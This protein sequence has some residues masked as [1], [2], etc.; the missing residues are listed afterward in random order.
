MEAINTLPTADR[1]DPSAPYIVAFDQGTTSSRTI[2]FNHSGEIVS[3]AQQELERSF[4]RPGW[5]Q[6]DAVDIWASQLSTFTQALTQA[7]IHPSFIAAAAIANQRE[8]TI[9]W[10]RTT[11]EPI[12]DAIVWQC[13]RGDEL[14]TKL[15]Q[16][17]YSELI[18]RKTGLIPDAYFSASKIAW[19]LESVEGARVKADAGRLAFGTVDSWLLW[20]FTQGK[21]HATD[22]TNASRT[23]LFDIHKLEFDDEL[24]NLFN[25]P[26]SMM[27]EVKLSSGLFGA[28]ENPFVEAS[29]PI[30]GVAGDQQAALFGQSCFE[31]GEAKNTYGTGCFMLMNTGTTPVTSHNGLLTTVAYADSQKT[32]YALEGSVFNAG[33]AVKW[34]RDSLKIVETVEESEAIAGS[35]DSAGGCYMVPAFNG[36]GAPHWDESARGAIVGITQG[37]ERAHIVRA[38]LESLAYQSADVLVAMEQDSG[39]SMREL[40]VDGGASANDF[41]LQFQADILGRNVIRPAVMEATALG[42]AYMAGLAVG[43]WAD[44]DELRALASPDRIFAPSMEAARVSD[45]LKG[46]QKAVGCVAKDSTN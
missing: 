19:I 42:A 11:G 20:N 2:I 27:P 1:R 23:M 35:V 30:T 36:L 4:P 5:V 37:T 39:V 28:I 38:T 3:I 43:F 21:T 7:N 29:I 41:V 22:V 40:R 32:N 10:D 44:E 17:G 6:Q 15:E 34:L 18:T 12:Y 25:I 8:T 14:I 45:L 26:R 33:S 9:V 24:L 46:W 13:R 16:E 31:P